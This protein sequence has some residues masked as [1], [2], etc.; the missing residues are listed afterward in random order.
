MPSRKKVV[1]MTEKDQINSTVEQPELVRPDQRLGQSN[2]QTDTIKKQPTS[3]AIQ[4]TESKEEVL[5]VYSQASPDKQ[6]VEVDKPIEEVSETSNTK[7]RT[8]ELHECPKCGKFMTLKTLKYIHEKTCSA[9]R[10]P[11]PKKEKCGELRAPPIRRGYAPSS[12]RTQ[13]TR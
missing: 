4:S 12:A 9:K 2:A 10:E 7:V 13:A 6:T 3:D 5:E 11:P 8:N 1:D